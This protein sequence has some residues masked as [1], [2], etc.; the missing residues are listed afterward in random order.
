MQAI[1]Q[2]SYLGIDK[3]GNLVIK[4]IGGLDAEQMVTA[5]LSL[6][7][8]YA[9]VQANIAQPKKDKQ[10]AQFRNGQSYKYADL[11]SVIAAI[12]E[13]SKD[14][15]I[16]YIQ[17]PVMDGGKSGV[18]NYLLNSK[19]AIMNFGAYLLDVGGA[20]PQ[21]AGGALTYARRYS[22]SAI[23]GIASEEDTDAQE[24]QSKPSYVSPNQL[25]GLT[26]MYNG[27][28]TD[29]STVYAKALAGDTLAKQVIMDKGN[30]VN[31]KV[32]IKS[33][34]SIYEFNKK[35]AELENQE[36]ERIRKEDEKAKAK[37]QES[38][39]K[40]AAKIID[41]PYT[42]SFKKLS[43]ETTKSDPFDE[44]MKKVR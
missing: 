1:D 12:Q 4:T 10:G 21:D 13:A 20:R 11:N 7:A 26:I 43:N 27:K 9:Q 39:D 37:K 2:P 31:T 23:F 17:Q 19:G 35:I 24:F 41:P 3:I 38:I 14:I 29:L 40:Q 44:A 28:R 6:L 34:N 30:S 16:A 22:I 8:A 5:K 33:I 36:K 18:I 32:A 42:E 25:A 15:D